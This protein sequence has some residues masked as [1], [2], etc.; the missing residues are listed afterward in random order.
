MVEHAACSWFARKAGSANLVEPVSHVTPSEHPAGKPSILLLFCLW[1]MAA[2]SSN[3]TTV[4][5]FG[6]MGDGVADD[7]SAIQRAVNSGIGKVAFPA[8]TYRLSGT[9][10]IQLDQVGP[11]SISG[12]GVARILMT[13]AGPAFRVAGS[14]QGTASPATVSESVWE[15]E[16][17][18][19]IDGLE[20]VGAHADAMG[21]ELIGTMQP[22]ITRLVVRRALHGLRLTGRNRNVIIEACHFYENRGVGIYLDGTNLHQINITSCHISYNQGGG[23]VVEGSEVRNLQVDACDIEANM[24]ADSDLPANIL[25]DAREN[26]VREV[27]IDGCTIQHSHEVPGGAN[28]RLLGPAVEN[29]HKVGHILIAGNLL[30]DTAINL[31]L[32][33]A[34]GVTLTGNSFWQGFEHNILV[35]GSSHVIVG[36]NLFDRNPDYRPYE[37]QN[38]VLFRDS[39]DCI[40]NGLQLTHVRSA[41]AALTLERCSGFIVTDCMILDSEGCG[42]LLKDVV[43]SRVSGCRIRPSNGR[44]Q[45]NICVEGGADNRIQ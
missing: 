3:P 25:I 19:L 8:G 38:S 33:F 21:I 34:R 10:D 6:A 13:S 43:D 20:I 18:P 31:H 40:L 32:R 11:V 28:I 36:N 45:R 23:I 41:R 24:S 2:C 7:T 5:D 30:S 14:H 1:G 9:I 37:S 12:D 22:T 44:R 17:A 26:S 15:Y 35:E 42:I 4:L 27:T 29:R 16:R 39:E